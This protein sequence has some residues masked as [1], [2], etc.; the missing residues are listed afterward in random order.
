MAAQW[1]LGRQRSPLAALDRAAASLTR[2]IDLN[3]TE[4]TGF[5]LGAELAE[6]RASWLLRQGRDASTAVAVGLEAVG[7]GLAINPR[8]GALLA[9]R[10]TLTW[11]SGRGA[12]TP[13][14]RRDAA[15]G[16]EH[17]WQQ[18]LAVNPLLAREIE[19]FRREA[20]SCH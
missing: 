16:A 18:A 3:P 9:H 19:P 11:M 10:G 13:E 6:V 17:A 8:S 14:A 15:T 20:S 1:A 5:E 12:S 2:A 7:R 4:I